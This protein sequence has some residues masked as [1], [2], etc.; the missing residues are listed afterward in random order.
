MPLSI[1]KPS[2][3][4]CCGL[5]LMALS[6]AVAAEEWIYKVRPGDNLWNL[7]ERHL[8]SMDYA[9]GLQQINNIRNPYV[10]PPG[11]HLRIPIAWVKMLDEVSAQ[12]ISVHGTVMLQRGSQQSMPIEMGMQ[13]LAGD[14]IRSAED[15]FVT[16]EFADKSL[17]RVQ[18][19]T[20]CLL[21]TSDAADD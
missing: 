6:V 1:L 16:I 12:V 18:E 20:H 21:Y 7:T 15:A 13:L 14:E 2:L 9:Q 3:E 8:K 4:K 17:L 5:L 19:N 10:I 11:T